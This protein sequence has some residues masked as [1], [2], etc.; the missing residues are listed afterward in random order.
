MKRLSFLLFILLSGIAIAETCSDL[1]Q[2]MPS[3]NYMKKEVLIPG[4]IKVKNRY[5]KT[6][7]KNAVEKYSGKTFTGDT[8]QQAVDEVFTSISQRTDLDDLAKADEMAKFGRELNGV[9]EEMVAKFPAK[10]DI[11][12]PDIAAW[13]L[14]KEAIDEVKSVKFAIARKM[15]L[16]ENFKP[17]DYIKVKKDDFVITIG[18]RQKELTHMELGQYEKYVESWVY[19]NKNPDHKKAKLF[20]DIDEGSLGVLSIGDI[21]DITSYN[22]WPMY[23]KEHDMRHIHYAFSH[24]MAIAA[25]FQTTRSKNSMRYVMM[26][27][28]YEG[29]DR[30]QYT[31]ETALNKFFSESI[32]AE[33]V[34]GINRNLDLEEAMLTLATASNKDLKA[35]AKGTGAEDQIKGFVEQL[36]D[37][38]PKIVEGTDFQG[39]ALSGLDFEQEIDMVVDKYTK[40]VKKSEAFKRKLLDNKELELTEKEE[41]FMKMTNY[42][43][44]SESPEIVIDGIRFKND[45]RGHYY[46]DASTR[47]GTED[48]TPTAPIGIGEQ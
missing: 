36:G 40:D 35:I 27:G 17:S 43:L 34:L 5:A 10:G 19:R 25:M 48:T 14:R 20:E 16:L 37:W 4:E 41:V 32:A 42:Q 45:G 33:K 15:A 3:G 21:R 23:L 38:K 1:F 13:I 44:N 28:L 46:G 22:L 18:D 47:W 9:F 26:G 30:I 11:N 7:I 31:H 24:P 8:F 6:V 39:K 12:A 2:S 29:V